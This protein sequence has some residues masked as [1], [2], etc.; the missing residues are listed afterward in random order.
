MIQ[1]SQ[2]H[3]KC[4]YS[5]LISSR[6][7]ENTFKRNEKLKPQSCWRTTTLFCKHSYRDLKRHKCHF[8]LAFG[9][10][11]IVVLSTL[12]V[13]S[14]V[15]KGPVIFL[16]VAEKNHGQVDAYILPKMTNTITPFY[17]LQFLNYT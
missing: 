7:S 14:I 15:S 9:S 8:C 11:L 2:T 6:I 1:N 16:R 17:S 5:I 3:L 12:L 10:I 13:S 4:K